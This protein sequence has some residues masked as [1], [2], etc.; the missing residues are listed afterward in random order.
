[1]TTV[2]F[3]LSL[4]LF[5]LLAA[6]APGATIT[7]TP[8]PGAI[9]A[10]IDSAKSG[11]TIIVSPGTYYERVRFPSP[12]KN[13]T[14]RST[15]PTSSTVVAETVIDGG[16]SG[17]VV[18][19]S[20]SELSSCVLSGLTITN[21]ES[22]AAGG[23]VAGN[24]THATVQYCRIVNNRSATTGGGIASCGGRI[25]NNTVTSNT[26]D[27]QGGGFYNCN[28]VI[29]SNRIVGNAAQN[30]GGGLAACDAIVQNNVIRGNTA[31]QGG[32]MALCDGRIQSNT[33]YGNSAGAQ[34]GG[35]FRSGFGTGGVKNCIL[36][37]NT[38]PVGPQTADSAA[39]TYCCIQNGTTGTG[40]ISA[41]PL[42]ADPG[43]ADFHLQPQ[44]PCIDA[45]ANLAG[46]IVTSRPLT[47]VFVSGGYKKEH[48]RFDTYL[49]SWPGYKGFESGDALLFNTQ[50]CSATQSNII[51]G[52]EREL[53]TNKLT[54]GPLARTN[55]PSDLQ[56]TG[57][58]ARFTI[59]GSSSTGG[60][61]IKT[62][63][64]CGG[65]TAQQT[66]HM[67]S[68]T[69]VT[70][71]NVVR[72][73]FTR[74]QLA[75]ATASIYAETTIGM[76]EEVGVAAT[77]I[78]FNLQSAGMVVY[79]DPVSSGCLRDFEGD[80]RPYDGVSAARGD[81]S[82]F[83][84][85]ADEFS[86]KLFLPDLVPQSLSWPAADFTDAQDVVISF[87]ALNQGNAV[88]PACQYSVKVDGVG[89]VLAALPALESLGGSLTV[90]DI[91]LGHL[92]LG[93][94]T[95]E[96]LLDSGGTVA[97]KDKTNNSLSRSIAIALHVTRAE[98]SWR[99]Y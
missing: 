38:A 32:A 65:Q 88:S 18:T 14:L 44:S 6:W 7:V 78:T 59:Q 97:E 71:E 10:A 2:R 53:K 94:H 37:A 74:D 39:P 80:V 20:G 67:T 36:W 92:S 3:P 16:T 24:G 81:G 72:G 8:G 77:R 11:D 66:T 45:G 50:S 9:Q 93:V 76:F 54:I 69:L 87:Q 63:L 61:K 82:D 42:F 17:S 5:I 15:R 90:E 29:D 25:Q 62:S 47:V 43:L 34:G 23:G 26:A 73:R 27:D 28:G 33:I 68:G 21:G 31:I 83:D 98:P 57:V 12:A 40:N 41:D 22:A 13:L 19:F 86:G 70:V 84:I 46:S 58:L 56:T 48:I 85:G 52:Q 51:L 1:M 95:I 99:L 35:L 96:V 79:H 4:F 30:N 55:V 75:A 64:Q 89:K 91:S 49:I 60:V